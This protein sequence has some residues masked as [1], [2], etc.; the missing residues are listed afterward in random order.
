MLGGSASRARLLFSAHRLMTAKKARKKT[1]QK[2][3]REEQ[4]QDKSAFNHHKLGIININSLLFFIS[5]IPTPTLVYQQSRPNP[6]V[7]F[8]LN[9]QSTMVAFP[10]VGA[11]PYGTSSKSARSSTTDTSKLD[12]AQIENIFQEM[13]GSQDQLPATPSNRFGWFSR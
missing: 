8:K 13:N 6:Q 1:N 4:E 11:G 7:S 3:T 2:D 10:V 12:A 9:L 5:Q